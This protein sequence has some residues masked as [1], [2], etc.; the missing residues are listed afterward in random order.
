MKQHYGLENESQ[1]FVT[2]LL[3]SESTT[4]P[5]GIPPAWEGESSGGL[6]V[7]AAWT[8]L[9]QDFP[10]QE[11]L[12]FSS[13]AAPSSLHADQKQCPLDSEASMARLV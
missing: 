2:I 3:G 9:C 11:L 12:F 13:P 4:H 7:T 6:R 5:H 10:F 8:F 1:R